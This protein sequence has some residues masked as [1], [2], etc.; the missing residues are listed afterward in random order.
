MFHGL[1]SPP[2]SSL[3]GSGTV[4]YSVAANTTGS[5]RTGTI[6]VAGSTITVTQTAFNAALYFPHVATIDSW[7]TEIAIINTS[8]S[9]SVTGTL[10]AL[11]DEG[12]LIE[13]KAVTLP[14]RGRR[15]I[16]VANEFT[17]HTNIGH[18]IFDTNSNTV[19]GYTKFYIDGVYRVAIP[20][21]K[22]VNTGDIYVTHIA[23]SSQWWTGL[24]LVN[25]TATEKTVTINFSDGQ[26]KQVTI[27][28]NGHRAFAIREL[29]NGQP[30]PGIE[31]AVITNAS[32]I[33]GLELFG[34]FFGGNQLEGILLT[35]KT[36]STLYYPHVESN[37][38]WTGIVAYNP[39]AFVVYDNR[40]TLR[41]PG[42]PLSPS[43]LSIPGKAKYIGTVTGLGLP[44]QTA[45][46]R[47]DST[48][49]SVALSLSVATTSNSLRA[50]QEMEGPV[51]RLAFLPR[52][53]SMG[54]PPSL[55]SILKTARH[56]YP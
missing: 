20:A 27:A 51:Q 39:S 14:A 41:C 10:R 42:D 12:Q 26:T 53:R 49:P 52:S 45:W 40:N 31:S 37:G 8:A 21:I 5:T 25:T 17:N 23:S 48:A 35:D 34:S 56:R 28:A 6:T 2:G 43:T 46:F 36:A 50:M 47:I 33:I 1:R 4:T 15:Q 19:Q 22:E 54:G 9:Q 44:A 55:W 38:W 7:Q 30:Q 16:I 11:N 3:T 13:T 29:F 18:I 32:G 24:S